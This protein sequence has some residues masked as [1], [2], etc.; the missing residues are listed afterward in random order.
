MGDMMIEKTEVEM[1]QEQLSVLKSENERIKIQNVSL[2]KDLNNV[3]EAHN[4]AIEIIN[5]F[6]ERGDNAKTDRARRTGSK[7]SVKRKKL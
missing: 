3:I 6:I 7:T 1:L 5:K 4:R 2:Q